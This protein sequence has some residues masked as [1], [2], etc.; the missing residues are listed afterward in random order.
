MS[1]FASELVP[2]QKTNAHF[3]LGKAAVAPPSGFNFAL[4]NVGIGPWPPSGTTVRRLPFQSSGGGHGMR[5]LSDFLVS[6]VK[7]IAFTVELPF[8]PTALAMAILS[9]LQNGT[10]AS[11]V[12]CGAFTD[13]QSKWYFALEAVFGTGVGRQAFGCMAKSVKISVPPAGTD[14]GLPTLSMDCLAIGQSNIG[15]LSQTAGT[16]DTAAPCQST[17]WNAT[18]APTAGGSPA[19]I[20]HVGFDL[21]IDNEAVEDPAVGVTPAGFNLKGPTI[22]GNIKIIGSTT[23]GDEYTVIRTAAEAGTAQDLV[24][25]W[26]TAGAT[27]KFQMPV[28]W[29]PPGA[30]DPMDN[31]IVFPCAFEGYYEDADESGVSLA[32][33]ATPFAAWLA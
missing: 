22:K 31:V 28:I 18:L 11:P 16:L 9:V 23:A 26:G 29:E 20:G 5:V 1:T 4:K 19:A 17:D 30:P 3:F 8:T 6:S 33:M 2:W 21:T 13:P 25:M 15:A 12:V 24:L 27:A 7:R 14:G 32:S 10:N